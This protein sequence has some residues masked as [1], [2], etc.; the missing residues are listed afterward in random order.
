MDIKFWGAVVLFVVGVAMVVGHYI[1]KAR[2]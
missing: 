1:A 2:R